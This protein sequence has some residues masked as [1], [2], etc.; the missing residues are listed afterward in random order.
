MPTCGTTCTSPASTRRA[1]AS[2][3]GVRDTSRRSAIS[4]SD[5]EASGASRR[6]RIAETRTVVDA[7]SAYFAFKLA[8][9]ATWY[10]QTPN[11][12]SNKVKTTTQ[13]HPTATLANSY[14]ILQVG[15]RPAGDAPAG[16]LVSADCLRG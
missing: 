1:I 16:L 8:K 13:I 3:T 14:D 2:R 4:V 11:D 5:S 6:S 15:R 12:P 7:G 10:H 9:P